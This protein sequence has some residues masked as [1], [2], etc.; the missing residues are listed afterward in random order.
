MHVKTVEG[1]VGARMYMNLTNTPMRIYK[2]A[3]HRGDTAAMERALGY[4]DKFT[5]KAGEY[6]VEADEGMEEDA[7]EAREKA[8]EEC[9]RAAR[10]REEERVQLE[11]RLEEAKNPTSNL[12]EKA[13][14]VEISEEGK[15]LQ[16]GMADTY[17]AA[18]DGSEAGTEKEPAT[19]KKTAE[20]G[21]QGQ[22]T[23]ID[24]FC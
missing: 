1:L 18:Y 2:E 4:A 21:C 13:D 22:G 6:K 10:K 11:K 7:K 14:I 8:K 16:K 9:E 17:A 19:Y 12:V 15:T 5:D 23:E 3:F 24:I 20:P